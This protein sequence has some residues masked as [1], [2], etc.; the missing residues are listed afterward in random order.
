HWAVVHASSRTYEAGVREFLEPGGPGQAVAVL[1]LV[2][3]PVFARLDPRP[4]GPLLAVPGDGLPQA[5]LEGGPGLPAEGGEL[6]AVERVAAVVAGAVVHA[7]EEGG[8]G[9]GELEDA[10]RDLDV[11]VL[12]AA[13]DV[14]D[15][16]RLAL[17]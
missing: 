1:P 15:L 7:A 12:V 16:A 14:V 8:V 10:L 11:L 5:V 6:R 13:A 3:L 17:A 4:P 9:R 2:V